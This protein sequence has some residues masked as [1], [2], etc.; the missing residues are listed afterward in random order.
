MASRAP[1]PVIFTGRILISMNV[2]DW[3]EGVSGVV[4][5]PTTAQFDIQSLEDIVLESKQ[6]EERVDKLFILGTR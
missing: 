1:V 4:S 2:V 3:A 6:R 5:T